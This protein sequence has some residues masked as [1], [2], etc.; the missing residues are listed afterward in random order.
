M[1]Q[2]TTPLKDLDFVI[3]EVLS[4]ET[5]LQILS[6]YADVDAEMLNA[7]AKES[8][9]FATGELIQM[10]NS[11]DLVGCKWHDGNVT[12][13]PDFVKTWLSYRDLGWPSM[14]EPPDF[15]GQGLPRVAFSM[16][17]EI[18][19][20]AS[21]AFVMIATVNHC[22]ANCL[23]TSATTELQRKWLPAL[24]TGEVLSSMCITE[25]QAGSDVGLISTRANPDGQGSYRLNGA[26][27]FVSGAEHDLSENILHLVLAR[28]PGSPSG[29][30]GLSLFLVPKYLDN[31]ELNG[32][33]CVGI[34]HKMGLHGSPTCSLQ[35]NNACGWLVGELNAGLKA[36]FPVMNEARLLTGAQSVGISEVALQNSL[37]YTL[38]RRQGKLSQDGMPCLLIEHI[39]VQRMLMT[40]KA[41]T[42]GGRAL[43]HWTALLLDQAD[44]HP[45]LIKR[46]EAHDLLSL[47]T[48]V[49]KGFLSENAQQSTSLALQLYGGYG[50]VTETGIEQLVRDVRI[51]TIY[52][53]TTTIQAQDLLMRKVLADSG[54]RLYFLLDLIR[55]WLDEQG[56]DDEVVPFIQSLSEL[57]ETVS[58]VTRELIMKGQKDLRSVQGASIH[59]LRLIGH[60]MFAWL[61]TKMAVAANRLQSET[62]DSWYSI[63]LETAT[64]YFGQLLPE[65]HTLV[66]LITNPTQSMGC[67]LGNLNEEKRHES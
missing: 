30:H 18:L 9:K 63:K 1:L 64:F 48:P 66:A 43:L 31:G 60:L 62:K 25:P 8:G 57:L 58:N 33:H 55:Q 11:A 65:T 52:E 46:D 29:T 26:K 15:G 67:L 39:D 14:C 4:A 19:S 42:E 45:E 59:Y 61:W 6:D 34:E 13:P 37:N 53:G 17:S 44:L 27:I 40:Q 49:V 28:V 23:R 10:N 22:T 51:T 20:S 56:S 32:V 7:I 50:Y 5:H 41:L 12:M 3:H 47:L 35:F 16:V 21:H 54:R 2:Y 38:E 36:M 24:A